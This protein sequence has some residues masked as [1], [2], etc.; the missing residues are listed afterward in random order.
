MCLRWC[1]SHTQCR[2]P[3]PP[4][5]PT[6]CPAP[7]AQ[8]TSL[9]TLLIFLAGNWIFIFESIVDNYYGAD[10]LIVLGFG[11]LNGIV[12]V[13]LALIFS[14]LVLFLIGAVVAARKVSQVPTFRLVS[15]N[16]PPE[17]TLA[18]GL[19]WHLFNSHIWGT[20][21]DAVAVIKK[22][23]MLLLPGIQV[24]LDVRTQTE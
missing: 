6:F 24:F 13:M 22:Q 4:P 1:V 10:P 3:A 14:V 18:L 11:E 5:T 21:Q 17:L 20:G 2:G 23:L 15:T 12:T 9:L 19:T 8:A 16:Q 7:L